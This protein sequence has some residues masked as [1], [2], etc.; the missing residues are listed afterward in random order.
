MPDYYLLRDNKTLGPYRSEDVRAWAAAGQLPATDLLCPVGEEKWA[1]LGEWPDLATTVPV[2]VGTPVVRTGLS[3]WITRGW[4]IVS[5]DA[6][7]FVVASLIV[8][9]LSLLTLG[10]CA[11]PLSAGL[12]IMALRKHDGHAVQSGDVMAGFKYFGA[13][14]GLGLLVA[15]PIMLVVGL[16]VGLG[17]LAGNGD[18]EKAMPTIQLIMQLPLTV[19]SYFIGTAVLFAI[20]LIVDRGYGS[21]QA[22]KESWAVVKPQFW[23]FLGAYVII[24]MISGAGAMLCFVG[25]L[26]TMPLAMACIIAVYREQFPAK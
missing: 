23:T 17:L 22:L 5:P 6:G 12:Y 18:F 13:T 4:E 9:G 2:A 16:M 11:P 8:M 3:A 1:P 26:F 10:I 14:W 21:I 20:P 19:F 24:Q 15:V 7:V 25:A